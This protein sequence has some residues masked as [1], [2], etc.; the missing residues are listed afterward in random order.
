M[1]Q[2]VNHMTAVLQLFIQQFAL[3]MTKQKALAGLLKDIMMLVVSASYLQTL[4][5]QCKV[6][7]PMATHKHWSKNNLLLSYLFK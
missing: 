2:T 6:L 3:T 4:Q 7:Y 5:G 1:L